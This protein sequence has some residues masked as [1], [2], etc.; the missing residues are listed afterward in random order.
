VKNDRRPLA[1]VI[2]TIAIAAVGMVVALLPTQQ[3]LPIANSGEST[4]TTTGES[5]VTQADNPRTADHD[6][7]AI[8]QPISS[9]FKY[10]PPKALSIAPTTDSS[11]HAQEARSNELQERFQQATIMLHAKQY[12]YAVK[13]LHRV[14]EL[15]P[16][17]PEAHSN[18]G[19]ALI[20]LKQYKA[21]SDFFN[22]AIAIR[23]L[24]LN[25][26]YGMAI[27]YEGQGERHLALGAMQ[28]FI[29]LADEDDPYLTKARAAMWEWGSATN[30]KGS[31]EAGTATSNSKQ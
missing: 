15:E 14:L 19:F 11:L 31:T 22:T 21:A 27:A 13:A 12:D 10:E 28:S 20:G 8:D 24:Q 7:S 3:P 1:L 9:P 25:A 6:S 4:P 5:H 17:L 18:M 29:H 23:P 16:R 30:D 26:Y 2:T